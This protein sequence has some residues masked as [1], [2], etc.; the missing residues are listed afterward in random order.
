[1]DEKLFTEHLGGFELHD[2][3]L[4]P[5]P[6]ATFLTFVRLLR[7]QNRTAAA[8]LLADPARLDAALAL[9][10]GAKPQA[11][12]WQLEYAEENA[13]WPTWFAIKFTGGKSGGEYIVHF[14]MKDVRWLIQDWLPVAK[15]GRP[16]TPPER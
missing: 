16:R 4:V 13:P 1:V 9:G 14:T 2:S 8:R 11:G 7:E 12:Q 3:R 10:W 15:P 5:S 6:Y